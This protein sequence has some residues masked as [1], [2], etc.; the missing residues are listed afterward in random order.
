MFMICEVVA[1]QD[2]TGQAP[3]LY[4]YY[5]QY[6]KVI[7]G[8]A[9]TLQVCLIANLFVFFQGE[10]YSLKVLKNPNHSQSLYFQILLHSDHNTVAC[11]L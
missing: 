8:L 6:H 3:N 7:L 11:N 1:P 9:W 2:H 10:L 5:Y 4:D